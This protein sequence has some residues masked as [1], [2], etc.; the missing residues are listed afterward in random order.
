MACLT[1]KRLLL[2][3]MPSFSDLPIEIIRDIFELYN[4]EKEPLWKLMSVC[5]TWKQTIESN[6]CLWSS[7]V[8]IN[9]KRVKYMVAK[10]FGPNPQLC[11]CKHDAEVALNRAKEAPLNITIQIRSNAI[12]Y[13]N[14]KDVEEVFRVVLTARERWQTLRLSNLHSKPFFIFPAGGYKTLESVTLDRCSIASLYP[15]FGEM[16]KFTRLRQISVK[17]CE[18]DDF[19][20]RMP[21]QF[22]EKVNHF[23]CSEY[24][25]NSSVYKALLASRNVIDATVALPDDHHFSGFL[26]LPHIQKLTITGSSRI[27]NQFRLP[28]LTKLIFAFQH[29]HPSTVT[30]IPFLPALR[31]VHNFG[32]LRDLNCFEAPLLSDLILVHNCRS[33]ACGVQ[34]DDW[35]TATFPS[36]TSVRNVSTAF[37]RVPPMSPA[38]L[39]ALFPDLKSLEVGFLYFDDQKLLCKEL[40]AEE[41]VDGRR[42]VKYLKELEV[43]KVTEERMQR[44]LLLDLEL[45]QKSRT[46]MGN[47]V[48]IITEIF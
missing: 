1:F 44:E 30:T 8:V 25:S 4:V 26:D 47:P 22:W 21:T 41:M 10:R 45:V 34:T 13:I 20:D 16:T 35:I 11:R 3:V 23:H 2:A 33:I 39:H 36:V 29:S 12:N 42:V 14:D 48:H 18:F 46:V 32:C 27:L 15:L 9:E 6:P 31:T 17:N 19:N 37:C 24:I 43:L 28:A 7:I 40:C 38:A 5:K